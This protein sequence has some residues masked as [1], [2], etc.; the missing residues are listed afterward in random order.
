MFLR[1]I[2]CHEIPNDS[3][4]DSN[5][6]A[7]PERRPPAVVHDNCGHDW[8]SKAGSD[9]NSTEDDAVGFSAFAHRKPTFDELTGSRIHCCFACAE[10]EAD[11]HKNDDSTAEPGRHNGRAWEA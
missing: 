11:E 2:S 5:C 9:T 7:E 1:G 10:C 8:G 6:R 3:R 4:N